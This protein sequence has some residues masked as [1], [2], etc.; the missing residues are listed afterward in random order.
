MQLA[1]PEELDDMT[2]AQIA[3]NPL[4]VVAMLRELQVP[5]GAWLVQS[6]AASALGRMVT[7]LAKHRG[8]KTA[9]LVRRDEHIAEL[10][11]LG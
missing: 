10:Q 9:G 11:Q 1:V 5:E 6:A 4:T 8:I 7:Q 3:V 2:A